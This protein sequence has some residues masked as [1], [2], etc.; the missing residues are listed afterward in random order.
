IVPS[1]IYIWV[2]YNESQ[3]YSSLFEKIKQTL[4]KIKNKKRIDIYSEELDINKDEL[5][6]EEMRQSAVDKIIAR[7]EQIDNCFLENCN[8]Q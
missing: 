5:F 6:I 3:E 2:I 8:N 4:G 7:L 1:N